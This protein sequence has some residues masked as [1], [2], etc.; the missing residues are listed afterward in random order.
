MKGSWVKWFGVSTGLVFGWGIQHS[1]VGQIVPDNTLGLERSR[2]N[3]DVQVRGDR[4]DQI[5]GGAVRGSALFHSFGNFNVGD[6]QRV[7]F[8]NPTGIEHIFSRVTG[9]N[10]SDILGTLGIEGPANLFLLNP[11][12]I[13]FGENARLEIA[14]SFMA[15][16]ADRFVFE[17]GQTFSSVN[18]EAPP[19]LTV[20]V[21]PGLQWGTD[22][23]LG[24]GITNQGNLSVG[25]S[26]TLAG[27]HLYLSGTLDAGRN[28]NVR[29]PHSIQIRDSATTPFIATAGN[30]LRLR[31]DS[32]DIFALNHPDSGLNAEGNLTL[33]SDNPVIGD[34]HFTAG[35][36]FRVERLG[37]SLGR[38]MSPNDPVI[39][40]AGDI[41]MADYTG[42]SLH[43]LAGGSV[44]I[45]GP[46]TITGADTLDQS[47]QETVTLSDGSTVVEIDGSGEP[48][49]DVRAGVRGQGSGGAEEQGSGSA[50]ILLGDIRNPGGT[51][52][53]S[54]QYRPNRTLSGG[55]IRV[56][57]IDTKVSLANGEA[58]SLIPGGAARGGD[59]VIDARGNIVLRGDV[60]TSARVEVAKADLAGL[61]AEDDI[62]TFRAVGGDILLFSGDSISTQGLDGSAIASIATP[63][64]R[65]PLED[66]RERVE[67][68]SG[69]AIA[70][71]GNI[72]AA[73]RVRR[74]NEAI[75]SSTGT[76]KVEDINISARARVR[77]AADTSVIRDESEGLVV[78]TDSAGVAIGGN[79]TTTRAQ[80]GTIALSTDVVAGAIQSESDIGS[81]HTG[82]INASASARPNVSANASVSV[83]FNANAENQ[84]NGGVATGGSVG[85]IV[86][87]G[88]SVT[89]LST[90]ITGDIDA[91]DTIGRIQTDSIR[92]SAIANT[93]SFSRANVETAA[94]DGSAENSGDGGNA[95]G[96]ELGNAFALGGA[97]SIITDV[98]VGDIDDASD[99]GTVHSSNLQTRAEVNH[100]SST[101]AFVDTDAS[102]SDLTFASNTGDGGRATGAI[103][104]NITSSGGDINAS[105]HISTGDILA[106]SDIG[107][108]NLKSIN[109][110]ST[111]EADAI[112]L[113]RSLSFIEYSYADAN[114]DNRGD[115]GIA[116]GRTVGDILG[117]GG[118]INLSTTV[119]MGHIMA[120]ADIGR[121]VTREINTVVDVSVDANVQA[122]TNAYVVA[123]NDAFNPTTVLANNRGNGGQA[124]GGSIG[125]VMGQG[126]NIHLSSQVT[127]G[128][129]DGHSDI[130]RLY[131]GRV[132]SATSVRMDGYADALAFSEGDLY[133]YAEEE[134]ATT[135]ILQNQGNGGRS[136]GGTVEQVSSQSGTIQ[137]STQT[138]AT[139]IDGSP[140]LAL[141]QSESLTT[142]AT[143]FADVSPD[144]EAAVV[145]RIPF[146]VE[147]IS[148]NG[149]ENGSE[150]SGRANARAQGGDIGLHSRFINRAS[151]NGSVNRPASVSGT[152]TINTL[153][154]SDARAFVDSVAEDQE[155]ETPAP[156]FGAVGGA[157]TIDADG[158]IQLGD[159]SALNASAGFLTNRRLPENLVFENTELQG[160]AIFFQA[161]DDI[162]LTQ[163]SAETNAELELNDDTEV[164]E[165]LTSSAGTLR[166]ETAQTIRLRDEG[167]LSVEAT[168]GAGEAGNIDIAAQSLILGEQS[169]ILSE[170]DSGNGGDITLNFSPNLSEFLVMG[171]GSSISTSAGT[172]EQGGN[173]G[174]ITLNA[175]FIL[176]IPQSDSDIT[177]NAFTGNGGNVSI[178]TEGI[179]GLVPRTQ[180]TPLSDITATSDLGIDG[181]I[182]I[183]TLSTDPRQGLVELATIPT[184]LPPINKLCDVTVAGG[185]EFLIIGQGGIPAAPSDILNGSA[186]WE[187]WHIALPQSIPSASNSTDEVG[188]WGRE[189]PIERPFNYSVV[190]RLRDDTGYTQGPQ[191]LVTEAQGWFKT[192]D[193]QVR[194][195][196]HMGTASPT[197][198][199][200]VRPTCHPGQPS[201]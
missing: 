75:R 102:S 1:A 19:L 67:R 111:I 32:I 146:D 37:G 87:R 27:Q 169:S 195:V 64:T 137:F 116:R 151:D 187:D 93:H 63:E 153:M 135:V 117:Q 28:L 54:N 69:G 173:G 90:V 31:G 78:N 149:G 108:I 165:T 184:D 191:R 114:S 110:P 163:I 23:N 81:I 98:A 2:I 9:S 125:T 58:V 79:V 83:Y 124:I 174:N 4:A 130:G 119:N 18:S 13:I 160:G 183:N 95:S 143:A 109:T 118:D 159:A 52:F 39:Q 157:I 182:D 190:E 112:A 175:R 7:Y 123:E 180:D 48:T 170:T 72:T 12:G 61:G 126:G 76:I 105:T 50:N 38:F 59:V 53:L 188:E 15:T 192:A 101:S 94:T 103:I 47:I 113:V 25:E 140:T 193:G 68:G 26:L 148:E 17:S 92:T 147:I 82:T 77:S 142:S 55:D 51:V 3:S 73:T 24:G 131:T 154:F 107:N 122:E 96:S 164:A 162:N 178:T 45:P 62:G 167:E 8:A 132:S 129:I 97:I 42:E 41:S 14:G 106:D 80:G 196:T 89:I 152:T 115:G 66:G 199:S 85:D 128:N 189:Y 133:S 11:N 201:T 70:R 197:H 6:Q 120:D 172:N 99:V 20:N 21:T 60:N 194:L 156:I 100:Y 161:N 127:A 16:T 145:S 186:L 104:T 43:I 155:S 88:G 33:R 44:T 49:L 30:H 134:I 198:S 84:G 34:A 71:G 35:G 36:A 56:G 10:R 139:V 181:T 136:V 141:I 121:L 57:K 29:S 40:A 86:S 74:G 138:E 200:I 177:A 91:A 22:A 150:E 144:A 166:I 185:S 46:I 179:F 5:T 168:G 158:R 171:P 65:T 176:A